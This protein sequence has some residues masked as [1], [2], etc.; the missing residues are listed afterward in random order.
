MTSLGHTGGG[1]GA[2]V[3]RRT[4][5]AAVI[6]GALLGVVYVGLGLIGHVIP[7]AQ[8]YTDGASLLADAA[9]STDGA[10]GADRFRSDRADRMYDNGGG[11]HRRDLGVL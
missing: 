2:K 8:S 5:I 6:A 4:S 7:N 9:Q 11:P 10:S 1:I 3:V